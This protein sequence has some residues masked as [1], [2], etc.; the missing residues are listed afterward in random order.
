MLEMGTS[1]SEGGV[2]LNRHPYPYRSGSRT[3]GFP[4]RSNVRTPRDD[5][6]G[7]RAHQQRIAVAPSNFCL[8]LVGVACCELESSRSC[9]Y[10]G[11]HTA[12]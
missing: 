5:R 6:H 9:A 10:E 8:R 1:G 2:A 7:G 12:G 3:A 4:A 11:T